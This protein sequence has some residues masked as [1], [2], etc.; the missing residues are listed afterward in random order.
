MSSPA[1][2]KNRETLEEN[3]DTQAT[4]RSS[5]NGGVFLRRLDST[6]AKRYLHNLVSV[7]SWGSD[8]DPS[9]DETRGISPTPSPRTSHVYV[10]PDT[11]PI[12]GRDVAPPRPP[13]KNETNHYLNIN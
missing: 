3:G 8:F 11:L 4:L 13:R 10:N 2:R 12:H 7:F 9:Q 6:S 1:A 5:S